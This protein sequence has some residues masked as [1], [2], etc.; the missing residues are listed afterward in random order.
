MIPTAEVS[1]NLPVKGKNLQK[2]EVEWYFSDMYTSE[3]TINY[4]KNQNQ[5]LDKE[6]LDV[7]LK[8]KIDYLL[9]KNMLTLIKYGNQENEKI[10]HA[11]YDNFTTKVIGGRLLFT[12]DI[13]V[14]I[15]IQEDYVLSF[16]FED[17]ESFFSFIVHDIKIP[18]EDIYFEQNLYLFSA[19]ILFSFEPFSE[20]KELITT[21][22]ESKQIEAELSTQASL[23][24]ETIVKLKSLFLEADKSKNVLTYLLILVFAYLYGMIHAIGPGH[25]K[26]LVA[27]Y[28]LSNERSYSKALFISLAIGV[29][30]TFSAFFLT[31]VIYFVIETFLV[32]FMENTILLTTKISAAI[33]IAIALYLL[34]K[35]LKS[36]RASKKPLQFTTTP[37]AISCGCGSCKVDQNSTDAALIISAGIIPCPG[38]VTIFIFSLSMG[39]YFLGFLSAFVMSLGMST[40]IFISAL[41][42]VSVRKK[43]LKENTKLKTILEYFS[44]ALIF[45]LGIILFFS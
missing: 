20:S 9:P 43:T 11:T 22:V 38:T 29:V 26:T 27:S 39:L 3:L 28:F 24:Q 4:D 8:T 1:L 21:N 18:S 17:D 41:I 2:I 7:V 19:A 36:Y 35:K 45:T 5:I 32:Q 23:L 12:F 33:I 42:S 34:Y 31:L 30:H 25:G 44:L 40:I 37:H 14:D 13:H 6:E 10:L 15:E 16:L